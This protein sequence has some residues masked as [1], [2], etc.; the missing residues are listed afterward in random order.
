MG[1]ESYLFKG[2]GWHGY[3]GLQVQ[4]PYGKPRRQEIQVRVKFTEQVS[5]LETQAGFLCCSHEAKFSLFQ[6]PQSLSLWPST[7]WMR[8]IHIMASL[9]AQRLK[10]L[11]VMRE[12]RVRSLGWE[13]PLEKAMATH[14]STPAWKIP[15]TEEP[16][17]LQSMGPQRVWHNWAIYIKLHPHYGGLSPLLKVYWFERESHLKNTF[18]SN[19]SVDQTTDHYNLAK[20][21]HKIN[22]HTHPEKFI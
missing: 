18:T 8:S 6:K 17:R 22:Y 4:K 11:P 14:S 15:W 1:R 21:T 5:R 3:G 16:G 7:Y 19:I 10:R 12:T 13:D 9:V 2:V 20:L